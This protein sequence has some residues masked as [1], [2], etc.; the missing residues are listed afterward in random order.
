MKR[1]GLISLAMAC[2]QALVPVGLVLASGSPMVAQSATWVPVKLD[3]GASG[4]LRAM[5][6]PASGGY[7]VFFK[8]FGTTPIHF[9]FY[10]LGAQ[11]EDAVPVN[12]RVHL[13]P[14]NP[15]GPWTIQ[16]SSAAQGQIRVQAVEVEVDGATATATESSTN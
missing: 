16:A 8:N 1:A 9:G 4:D 11:T 7:Q 2:V 12:G 5:V 14:G 13:K 3:Q 10:L 6:V 15:A